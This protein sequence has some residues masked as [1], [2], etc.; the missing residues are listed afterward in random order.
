MPDIFH[1]FPIKVASSGVFRAVSTPAELDQ[2][3]TVRSTG[4]PRLHA[5][6][7]LW[8]GPGYDWRATV[9]RCQPEREFEL[10]LTRADQE[11]L[12]TKV[13]FRLEATVE[14]RRSTSIIGGGRPRP[15]TIA[16]RATAGR[17]TSG[18]CGVIS[19]MA[20]RCPTSA[21][22]TFERVPW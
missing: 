10:E 6:Y 22:S 14:S 20:R 13:G 7:E 5:E 12:G 1:D 11:W 8:F 18:C 9:A 3:W 4:E 17:C 21:A 19:S 16:Y 2:W 15:S